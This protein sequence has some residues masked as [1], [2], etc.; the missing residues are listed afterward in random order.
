MQYD[1]KGFYYSQ[2][3]MHILG[4]KSHMKI[5]GGVSGKD[6]I[7]TGV[8]GIGKDNNF[9]TVAAQRTK[10]ARLKIIYDENLIKQFHEFK[11]DEEEEFIKSINEP[12]IVERY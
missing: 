7:L 8:R 4:V 9:D 1:L 5:T 12:E 2:S 10:E 11:R 6:I 3:N